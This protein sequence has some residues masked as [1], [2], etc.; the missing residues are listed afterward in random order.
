MLRA[1]TRASS[2]LAIRSTTCCSLVVV[3]LH[4]CPP[5]TLLSPARHLLRKAPIERL[6]TLKLT[7]VTDKDLC[8]DAC[9]P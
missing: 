4:G 8:D 9:S 2:S 6:T 1:L 7:L 3:N 5:S